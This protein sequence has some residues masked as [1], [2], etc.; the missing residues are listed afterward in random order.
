MRLAMG[1]L[2]SN[3]AISMFLAISSHKCESPCLPVPLRGCV[4]L[5]D[6]LR[7]ITYF[8]GL[9]VDQDLRARWVRSR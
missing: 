8:I 1:A 9:R 4:A 2:G 7:T 3:K 6:F 5:P